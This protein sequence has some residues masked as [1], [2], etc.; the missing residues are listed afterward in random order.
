MRVLI[1]GID[2]FVGSH[3]AEFLLR[4]PGVE[5]HGT[6]LDPSAS[7]LI[8]HIESK[9]ILHRADIVDIAST[10]RLVAMVMPDR[11]IHIAGQAFIPTS[12]SDPADTFRTNV[13]GGVS[14]LDASR[15]LV[16]RRGK[17]PAVLIVSSAEVYGHVTPP[18]SPS[19]RRCLSCLPTRTLPARRRLT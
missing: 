16:Q 7:R 8:R 5:I 12:I 6:I 10:E 18:A 17:G 2:G 9:L 4:E 3:M 19:P 13:M 11:I 14:I 15:R 1:T